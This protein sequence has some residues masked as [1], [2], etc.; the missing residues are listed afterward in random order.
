MMGHARDPGAPTVMRFVLTRVR[1]LVGYLGHPS[2][3]ER[4]V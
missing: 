1:V 3:D 2:Q 4:K